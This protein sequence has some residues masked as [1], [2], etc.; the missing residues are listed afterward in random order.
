MTGPDPATPPDSLALTVLRLALAEDGKLRH[1]THAGIAVRGAVFAELVFDGRLRGIRSPLPSGAAETGSLLT[2]S[3]FRAVQGRAPTQ[4]K[5]WYSH[6]RVDTEAAANEL[7]RLAAWTR[8]EPDRIVDALTDHTEAQLR[9][10]LAL[11]DLNRRLAM[12]TVPA[13]TTGGAAP[14][15]PEDAVVALLALGA[16]LRGDRPR[17]KAALR[18]FD[19]LLPVTPAPTVESP[20][21]WATLRAAVRNSLIGIRRQAGSRLLSG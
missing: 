16:G 18:Q 4:W 2:D 9:H 20:E 1:R 11:L 13:V 3:V 7:V 17:P 8:A 5:R 14:A 6:A 10:V 21:Q 12:P 15:Q 19:R